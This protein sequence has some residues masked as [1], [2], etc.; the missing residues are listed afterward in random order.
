MLSESSWWPENTFK[1][2]PGYKAIALKI[3]AEYRDICGLQLHKF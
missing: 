1:Q 2:L 3:T